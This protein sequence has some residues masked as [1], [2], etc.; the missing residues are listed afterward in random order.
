MK[1]DSIILIVNL[2]KLLFA[3]RAL[4]WY[5]SLLFFIQ[6]RG[7]SISIIFGETLFVYTALPARRNQFYPLQIVERYILG[8][9]YVNHEDVLPY[10]SNDEVPIRHE[11]FDKFLSKD[12]TKGT[13]KRNFGIMILWRVAQWFKASGL[14]L[15]SARFKPESF[16]CFSGST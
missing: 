12:E 14:E 4:S 10:M 8:L 3:E 11:L 7:L 16:D 1:I 13:F 6:Y 5:L 9:D 15:E 2:N